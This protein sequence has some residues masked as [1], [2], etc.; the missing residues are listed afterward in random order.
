MRKLVKDLGNG[1]QCKSN[2]PKR[3]DESSIVDRSNNP[4]WKI[5]EIISAKCEGSRKHV[6]V[7]QQ[8]VGLQTKL[9][10]QRDLE[11]TPHVTHP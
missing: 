5:A 4:N 6:L 2:G 1:F 9:T 8:K 10:Y 7:E 3:H 11:R